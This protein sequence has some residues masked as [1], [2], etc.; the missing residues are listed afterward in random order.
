MPRTML[1]RLTNYIA[2][3]IGQK[4]P[5]DIVNSHGADDN[6]YELNNWVAHQKSQATLIKP[7]IEF[8]GSQEII[9]KRIHFH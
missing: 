3:A 8:P 5:T 6:T 7:F 2:C 1:G 4:H 9:Y